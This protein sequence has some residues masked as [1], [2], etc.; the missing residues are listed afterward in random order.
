MTYLADTDYVA[1]YLKGYQKA[2]DVLT[3]LV[4]YGITI[5]II[6]FA[7]VYEGI[8]YGQNRPQHEAGFRTFLATTPVLSI[9]LSVARQFALIR[10]ALRAK[11]LLI[12]DPDLYI[13]STALHYKLTLL[14]RNIKD[15]QR[16]PNLKIYQ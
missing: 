2:S 10:G 15:Y 13:A 4:F 8:Y 14:S 11:G 7:E 1:D 9:T 3:H 6:T 12:P 5:S 16:I